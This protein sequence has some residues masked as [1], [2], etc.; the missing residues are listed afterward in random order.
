MPDARALRENIRELLRVGRLPGRQSLR[1]AWTGPGLDQPCAA[2]GH[3]L[4]PDDVTFELEF[5]DSSADET[6]SYRLH[7]VCFEI[8]ELESQREAA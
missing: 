4:T 8:W 3:S 5:D 7:A 1:S 2:C 6:A